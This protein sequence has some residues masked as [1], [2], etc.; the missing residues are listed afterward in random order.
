MTEQKKGSLEIL[1][2][3]YH[4]FGEFLNSIGDNTGSRKV[5][6]ECLSIKQQ[7]SETKFS[8]DDSLDDS[9]CIITG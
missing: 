5:L 6:N 8:S 2:Q 7:L 1:L 4:A 9:L 3:T